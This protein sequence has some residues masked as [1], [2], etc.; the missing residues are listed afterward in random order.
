[1]ALSKNQV[2]SRWV[3]GLRTGL[4]VL[5]LLANAAG[6]IQ[7]N[8]I[9]AAEINTA[10]PAGNAPAETQT[11]AKPATANQVFLDPTT[12]LLSNWAPFSNTTYIVPQ[13]TVSTQVVV[14]VT[15]LVA[16]DATTSQFTAY[17]PGGGNSP[18][19]ATANTQVNDFTVIM[20]ASNIL[21]APPTSGALP[22]VQFKVSRKNKGL[23]D[24]DACSPVHTIFAASRKIL[25][26]H[27]LQSGR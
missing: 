1:M 3:R 26:A 2:S 15:S 14:S 16:L 10:R 17:T 25:F 27:H 12:C 24:A 8:A 13:G 6:S 7:T 20:T 9:T 23:N 18:W 22:S 19:T 4:A 11:Q 5:A 21:V